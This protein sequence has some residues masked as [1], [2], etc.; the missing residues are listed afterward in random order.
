MQIRFARNASEPAIFVSIDKI[1]GAIKVTPD[2]VGVDADD[3]GFDEAALHSF[4]DRLN[5]DLGREF[6]RAFETA[7]LDQDTAEPDF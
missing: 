1:E 7:D 3:H 6:T 2:T 5:Q 4:A